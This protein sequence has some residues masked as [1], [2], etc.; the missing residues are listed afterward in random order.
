MRD[1]FA[2]V[3]EP[4]MTWRSLPIEMPT[5]VACGLAMRRAPA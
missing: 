2:A 3:D 4:G 1:F 5:V